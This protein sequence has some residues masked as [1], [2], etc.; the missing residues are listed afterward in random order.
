MVQA[1]YAAPPAPAPRTSAKQ[2]Q[3]WRQARQFRERADHVLSEHKVTFIEWLLLET[4]EELIDERNDAVSQVDVARRS[5]LSE[6]VVSYWMAVMS[7]VGAIDRGPT[8]DGRAW[9]VLLTTGGQ[10]VLRE[11]NHVLEEAGLSG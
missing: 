7:Q 6:R 2:R 4:L 8:A 11:C 9:R 3:L 1:G 10:A 5:G